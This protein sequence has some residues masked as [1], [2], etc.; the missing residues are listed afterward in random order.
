[1]IEAEGADPRMI[2]ANFAAA[3]L[4][5]SYARFLKT[6]IPGAIRETRDCRLPHEI[7]EEI[8]VQEKVDEAFSIGSVRLTSN[9]R[10]SVTAIGI[11]FDATSIDTVAGDHGL[12]ALKVVVSPSPAIIAPPAAIE[13]I[14]K[15]AQVA[16]EIIPKSMRSIP[17]GAL[18]LTIDDTMAVLAI[19]RTTA[20]KLIGQGALVMKKT[21]GRSHVTMESVRAYMER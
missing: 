19:G 2:V 20:Y 6:D 4:I 10:V 16:K 8:I 17:E 12:A 15:P 7:W 13:A 3:G 5:K 9:G 1:M 18:Q 11:R 14:E 21:C